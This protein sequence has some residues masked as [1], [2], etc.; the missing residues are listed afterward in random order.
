MLNIHDK[1]YR[2]VRLSDLLDI[3][4]ERKPASEGIA[5]ILENI[6]G[7]RIALWVDG[8]LKKQQVVIKSLGRLFRNYKWISGGAVLGDGKINLILDVNELFQMVG[9]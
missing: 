5:I 2:F 7:N 1:L 6:M 3:E 8:I 9:K 4:C